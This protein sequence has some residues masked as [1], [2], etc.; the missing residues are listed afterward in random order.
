LLAQNYPR[1]LPHVHVP[2]RIVQV[3]PV[4]AGYIYFASDDFFHYSIISPS[5]PL[6]Y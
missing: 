2:E 1:N 4:A 5:T 3:H 6:N